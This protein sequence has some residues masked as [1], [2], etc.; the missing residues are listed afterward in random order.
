MFET[1]SPSGG[2]ILDLVVTVLLFNTADN[3]IFGFFSL[4][5]FHS[6]S[7]WNHGNQKASIITE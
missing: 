2:V 5:S 3:P 4:F 1:S 6:F 7:G